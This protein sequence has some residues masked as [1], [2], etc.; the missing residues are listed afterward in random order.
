MLFGVATVHSGDGAVVVRWE[1]DPPAPSFFALLL[2]VLA[3]CA[4]SGEILAKIVH[5]LSQRICRSQ[6]YQVQASSAG[7]LSSRGAC[8]VLLRVRYL[9]ALGQ[10]TAG[11][12]QVSPLLRKDMQGCLRRGQ[13]RTGI[14]E[15][16]VCFLF[17]RL[18]H[19]S[20]R[21]RGHDRLPSALGTF[22]PGVLLLW[23]PR[24]PTSDG[25][26]QIGCSAMDWVSI[27]VRVAL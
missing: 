11:Q 9:G 2:C 14:C 24:V 15:M 21:L 19:T 3:Y 5:R 7:S 10:S 12:N 16:R 13:G 27:T 20:L 6:A 4:I 26:D 8:S 1:M 23:S 18:S 17:R 22:M 25:I